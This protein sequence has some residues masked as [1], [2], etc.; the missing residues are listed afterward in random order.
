[1]YFEEWKIF[2]PFTTS[3]C[4]F[5]CEF[6]LFFSQLPSLLFT[7]FFFYLTIFHIFQFDLIIIYLRGKRRKQPSKEY[8]AMFL[9]Q[10]RHYLWWSSSTRREWNSSWKILFFRL[11]RFFCLFFNLFNTRSKMQP[12]VSALS[13]WYTTLVGEMEIARGWKSWKKRKKQFAKITGIYTLFE[14]FYYPDKRKL[15]TSHDFHP[16]GNVDVEKW[17]FWTYFIFKGWNPLESLLFFSS[18]HWTPCK[19]L[20]TL[21]VLP[22]E[23]MSFC[24]EYFSFNS[25]IVKN[26]IISLIVNIMLTFVKY[27]TWAKEPQNVILMQ[28]N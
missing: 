6:F 23:Q 20:V 22:R 16:I 7:S 18:G 19:L 9:A 15:N 17:I 1:M 21:L 4:L 10:V 2:H 24:S 14:I 11:L 3:L 27:Y 5:G 25:V 12:H 26:Y 8:D 13:G 28:F